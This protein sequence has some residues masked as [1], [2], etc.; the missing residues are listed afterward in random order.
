MNIVARSLS[1][2]IVPVLCLA[3]AVGCRHVDKAGGAAIAGEL[4]PA[5]TLDCDA[6][7][8][9]KGRPELAFYSA[10][11]QG[12]SETKVFVRNRDGAP[13]RLVYL[14]PEPGELVSVSDDGARGVYRRFISPG[15]TVDVAI[16]LQKGES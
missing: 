3:G 2:V 12:E 7:I 1:L 11:T 9:P 5:G 14:D 10:R 13:P 6:P 4:V 16:D 8:V 15:H